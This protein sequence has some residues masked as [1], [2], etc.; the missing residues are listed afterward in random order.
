MKKNLKSI[1]TFS[2]AFVISSYSFASIESECAQK[3]GYNA[4]MLDF[5]ASSNA[6]YNPNQTI[7]TKYNNCVNDAMALQTHNSNK[8][9]HPG[10]PPENKCAEQCKYTN[11]FG[12]ERVDQGC[13]DTCQSKFESEMKSYQEKMQ[14]YA[15]WEATTPGKTEVSTKEVLEDLKN[16]LQ[17]KIDSL[18]KT[19]KIIHIIAAILMAVGAL[20]IALSAFIFT[21]WMGPVGI[22]LVASGAALQLISDAIINPKVEK[23]TNQLQVTCE[24]YNKVATEKIQ[25]TP[26]NTTPPPAPIVI[27]DNGKIK[28]PDIKDMIDPSTG[29]CRSSAPPECAKYVKQAPDGCFKKGGSCMAVPPPN[30][31]VNPKTGK[32]EG[33]L[34]GKN[35][36]LGLDDFQNEKSMIAA[37]FTPGQAKQFMSD[38]NLND[39]FAKQGL[40]LKGDL[41][42]L[43]KQIDSPMLMPSSSSSSSVGPA[44]APSASA[45][46]SDY[47]PVDREVASAPEGVNPEWLI[48]DYKGDKVGNEQDNLFKMINRRYHLKQ[49]QSNFLED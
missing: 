42:N 34:N 24:S 41:K 33:K 35:V 5:E 45:I 36:S 7:I 10:N 30:I 23:L 2:L 12:Q 9:P 15:M 27:G 46:K 43:K 17:E 48:K 49:K 4:S 25:C 38:F 21:S 8:P 1:I 32:V 44:A 14:A 22:A 20:F 29:N 37:G 11:A 26:N 13:F 19:Q 47:K 6:P 31:Q 3:T 40:D 28:F 18:K 39:R 16:K